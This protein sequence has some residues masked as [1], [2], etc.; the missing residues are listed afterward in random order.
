MRTPCCLKT[1]IE[2]GNSCLQTKRSGIRAVPVCQPRNVP[3]DYS[4]A[5]RSKP[6]SVCNRNSTNFEFM[7][8]RNERAGIRTVKRGIGNRQ[9]AWTRSK[10]HAND[11]AEGSRLFFFFFCFVNFTPTETDPISKNENRTRRERFHREMSPRRNGFVRSVTDARGARVRKTSARR[12]C[13]FFFFFV[14]IRRGRSYRVTGDGRKSKP[15]VF[16]LR[17]TDCTTRFSLSP[18]A[19]QIESGCYFHKWREGSKGRCEW[20]SLSVCNTCESW[21]FREA[22]FILPTYPIHNDAIGIL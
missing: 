3:G 5:E 13:F 11:T 17:S 16:R 1:W 22:S 10:N 2:N 12:K 8:R 15:F 7:R 9:I 20:F 14:D 19:P 21:V 6:V 4:H 18:V